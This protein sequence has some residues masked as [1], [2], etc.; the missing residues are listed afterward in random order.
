MGY[1]FLSPVVDLLDCVYTMRSCDVVR[2]YRDD[3]YM[4]G[5]LLQHVAERANMTPNRLIIHI[6]NLHCFPG[7][8]PF[9]LAQIPKEH[10]DYQQDP[11]ANYNYGAL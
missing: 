4:A 11:R 10:M 6:D 9:L 3:V 7:D 1:H 5:R 8:K 2:F